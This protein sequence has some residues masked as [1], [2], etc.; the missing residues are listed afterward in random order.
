M[1]EKEVDL[2]AEEVVRLR[3]ENESLRE[4]AW[5]AQFKAALALGKSVMEAEVEIYNPQK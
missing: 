5:A 1:L 2:L 3:A 4:E